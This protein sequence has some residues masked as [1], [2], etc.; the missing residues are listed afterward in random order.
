M[1]EVRAALSAGFP[2]EVVTYGNHEVGH[3]LCKVKRVVNN[4]AFVDIGERQIGGMRFQD[5]Q[6]WFYTKHQASNQES[7]LP[8]QDSYLFVGGPKDGQFWQLAVK[9][10][11]IE[12]AN[13]APLPLEFV[14]KSGVAIRPALNRLMT[15]RLRECS[16]VNFYAPVSMTDSEAIRQLICGYQPSGG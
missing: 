5:G 14:M 4:V 12:A 9:R 7:R 1:N 3:Q 13:P 11:H 8:Q 6:R 15:Y 16:G 10:E 2:V